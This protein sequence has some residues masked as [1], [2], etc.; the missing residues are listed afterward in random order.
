MGSNDV[1][2]YANDFNRNKNCFINYCIAR[3]KKE[4]IEMYQKDYD[5]N[6]LYN[7]TTL[8]SYLNKSKAD[9][10][11]SWTDIIEPLRNPTSVDNRTDE[12]IERD[13]IDRYNVLF[14]IEG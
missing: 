7:M 4:K 9:G 10:L 12:Q 3:N 8:L 13:T 11:K 5:S 1:I 6:R 14:G 2:I